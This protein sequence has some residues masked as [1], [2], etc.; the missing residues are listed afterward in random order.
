LKPIS[1]RILYSADASTMCCWDLMNAV[2]EP[3]A[4]LDQGVATPGNGV[5]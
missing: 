5:T 2:C 1:P 4:A 3:R